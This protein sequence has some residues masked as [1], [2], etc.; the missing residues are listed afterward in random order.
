[1]ARGQTQTQTVGP[2]LM[3]P[4]ELPIAGLAP[5]LFREGDDVGGVP[6]VQ[7]SRPRKFKV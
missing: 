6:L 2:P 4:L 5:Q 3:G 1:M 7:T